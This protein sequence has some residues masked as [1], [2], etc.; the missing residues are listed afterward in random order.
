M[1]TDHDEPATTPAMS[2]PAGP[3]ASAGSSPGPLQ[4][5]DLIAFLQ[6]T[7]LS[8]TQGYDVV[9]VLAADRVNDL[10]GQQYVGR[11]ATGDAFAPVS[12]RVA[13]GGNLYASFSGLTLGPPLISFSPG[14]QPQDANLRVE[15]LSGTVTTE[16]V[17]NDV[18]TVTSTQHVTPGGGFVL[19]GVVPLADVR[20]DADPNTHEVRLDIA[21]GS[22][23]AAHMNIPGA[24]AHTALGQYFLQL[25][26]Q[27]AGSWAYV[28]G[29]LN[30]SADP[31]MKLVPTS[32]EIATQVDS[33]DPADT[34]RVLLFITTAYG[35]AP[36]GRPAAMQL[37]NMVPAGS[38]T[39]LI[40]ANRVLF[41]D[42]VR[43]AIQSGLA[44]YGATASAKPADP[45]IPWSLYA[46]TVQGG[47]LN[48]GKINFSDKGVK[49]LS[50][51]A[52]G[53][54]EALRTY[55]SDV[56]VPLGGIAIT[57]SGNAISTAAGLP[58]NQPWA[59]VHAQGKDSYPDVGTLSMT[60]SITGQQTLTVDAA[61][62]INVN[63]QP[64]VSV[65]FAP[66]SVPWWDSSTIANEAGD[67]VAAQARPALEKALSI[68][69]PAIST[70]AVNNLLFPED[71]NLTFASA[72]LPGDLVTFG[73]LK[74][75]AITVAPLYATLTPGQTFRFSASGASGPGTHWGLGQN[76]AGSIGADGTY[77][78]P[79]VITGTTH[80]V[81]TAWTMV[82]ETRQTAS[83][84]VTI[85]PAGLTV[86]P[87]YV[88]MAP[89]A[90]P[91]PFV[92]SVAG[93]TAA[94]IH[95]SL[96]GA[97][98]LTGDGVYTPPNEL[99]AMQAVTVRATRTSDGSTADALLV[100]TPY[101]PQGVQASPA[102]LAGPLPAG[103]S[104]QFTAATVDAEAT[105]ASI[106]WSVLPA[107]GTIDSGLYTAPKNVTAL[108]TVAVVATAY[109]PYVFGLATLQIAP[110]PPQA[111][112]D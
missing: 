59:A 103:A 33:A 96:V 73:D 100:L 102:A 54:G 63:G 94:D 64:S 104:Q 79:D 107:I 109:G 108:T 65:S 9:S 50:G 35:T 95:W 7:Q 13:I 84:V 36:A 60:A 83:A 43:D 105:P 41:A 42:M 20:G 15:F 38:T 69:L 110:A 80:D 45:S 19:T 51:T 28:L 66:P 10:F 70:F 99:K 88:V 62:T 2:Q 85:V 46:V 11:V 61:G 47:S 72:H 81:V 90:A 86:S 74:T 29:S 8:C 77:Q 32:F 89:G 14:A 25:M 26:Q 18:T 37:Q 78:A 97:G 30:Y 5:A 23:F 6:R 49:F 71:H 52:T 76:P 56:V 106:T 39:T 58:W 17:I 67:D 21:N 44:P 4:P 40:V 93:G 101:S 24:A 112:S 22:D 57:A 87:D 91:Q 1:S 34:G 48:V 55:P 98:T 3:H 111:R 75:S 82:G 53:D 68:Q 27:D 92:A 31:S 12:G 16:E